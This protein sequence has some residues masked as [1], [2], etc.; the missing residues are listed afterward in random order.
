MICC[1]ALAG[2]SACRNCNRRAEYYY[3]QHYIDYEQKQINFIVGDSRIAELE[4]AIKRLNERIDEILEQKMK[5]NKTDVDVV[6][7]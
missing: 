1:C 5:V 4:N 6:E 7:Q 3:P 2:T